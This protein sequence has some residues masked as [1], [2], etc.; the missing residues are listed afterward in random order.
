MWVL[1][2]LEVDDLGMGT[3]TLVGWGDIQVAR[4]DWWVWKVCRLVDRMACWVD[5]L[6]DLV[7]P[8]VELVD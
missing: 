3:H 8:Q 2:S 1:E 5:K 6:V 4:V 7:E